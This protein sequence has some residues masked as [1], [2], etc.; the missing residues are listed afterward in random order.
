[1]SNL[2]MHANTTGVL[3]LGGGQLIS[4]GNNRNLGNVTNGEA[5]QVAAQE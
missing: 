4:F 1:M 3:S 2:E 5:T